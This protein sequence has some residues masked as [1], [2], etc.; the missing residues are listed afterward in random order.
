VDF[1]KDFFNPEQGRGGGDP[2]LYYVLARVYDVW[3]ET[4]LVYLRL[5][6][7]IGLFGIEPLS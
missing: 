6:S 5:L 1:L 7:V 4:V 3:V 2:P